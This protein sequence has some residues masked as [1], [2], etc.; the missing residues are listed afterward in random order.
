MDEKT[1]VLFLCTG[2]T[3]RSQMAEALLNSLGGRYYSAYSAGLEPAGIN[4]YTI[5]VMREKGYDL[6]GHYSK[7]LSTYLG[8]KHFGY[9]ITLCADAEEK[10]P[11]FPGMGLRIY[12]PFPDPTAITGNKQEVLAVFRDVRNG[13]ELKIREWLESQGQLPG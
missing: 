4:P 12:W 8:K 1:K 9:L 5:F 2:N 3:A 6:S 7:S 11:V 13:I 10:C